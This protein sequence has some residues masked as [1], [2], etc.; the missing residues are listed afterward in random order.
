MYWIYLVFFILAV[1]SH[2]IVQHGFGFISRSALEELLILGLGVFGF[3]IYMWKDRQINT[4]QEAKKLGQKKL[5][6]AL[7][8]LV[9]S[10]SYI[11]EVNRKMDILMNVALGLT[12]RSTLNKKKEEEI[13]HTIINAANSLAQADCSFLR[14]I[15]IETNAI[16]KEIGA[17]KCKI[18]VE[19]KELIGMHDG[20]NVKKE[21]GTL[22]VS[23]RQTIKKIRSFLIIQNYKQAE[24]KSEELLKVLA[25]QALFV[26][27]LTDQATNKP[28]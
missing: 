14:L 11:G 17:H 4:E 25:S 15:N 20:I 3:G 5:D 12:D 18:K 7:K 27:S 16:I 26:H 23:S 22:V 19:M 24:E 13:Y 6:R 28:C 9:E 2:D 1:F 21:N 10:Y 8:D